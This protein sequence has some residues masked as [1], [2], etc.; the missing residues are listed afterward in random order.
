[1]MR[2]ESQKGFAFSQED[3]EDYSDLMKLFLIKKLLKIYL[4]RLWDGHM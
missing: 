4:I 2:W 1:M 3:I